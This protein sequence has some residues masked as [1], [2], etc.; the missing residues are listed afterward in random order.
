MK[1]LKISNK[2]FLSVKRLNISENNFRFGEIEYFR[3]AFPGVERLK[4]EDKLFPG[5]ERL[6]ISGQGETLLCNLIM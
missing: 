6:N 5:V 1:R 2:L 3:E 4:I